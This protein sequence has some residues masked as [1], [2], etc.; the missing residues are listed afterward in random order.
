M[1][2]EQKQPR[3]AERLR[4]ELM[5]AYETP[6]GLVTDWAVNIS[7]SGLFINTKT[8]LP[9]GSSIKIII[10]LPDK[11]RPFE[12]SGIVVR[13]DGADTP[14][15]VPGL[16]VKFEKIDEEKKRRLQRFVD[17]LKRDFIE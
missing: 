10:S 14:S 11:L 17:R 6:K 12:L 2:D 1:T 8:F 16:G 5:V 15:A 3:V 9:V 13:V 4:H 7:T